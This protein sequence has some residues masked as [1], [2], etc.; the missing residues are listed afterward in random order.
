MN[1]NEKKNYVMQKTEI[2]K[3]ANQRFILNV[4]VQ[5]LVLF[6][7]LKMFFF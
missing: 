1:L 4:L 7:K 6:L 3:I 2:L 5:F